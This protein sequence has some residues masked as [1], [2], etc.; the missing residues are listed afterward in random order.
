MENLFKRNNFSSNPRLPIDSEAVDMSVSDCIYDKYKNVSHAIVEQVLPDGSK[1]KRVVS[2]VE[3][4]SSSF[5]SVRAIVSE[6]YQRMLRLGLLSQ[7]HE[8]P[9][10]GRMSD[11]ELADSVIPAGLESDEV[12]DILNNVSVKDNSKLDSASEDADVSN[13]NSD[14][15][16]SSSE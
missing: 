2:D 14:G 5:P 15:N 10:V 1:V 9:R 16:S 4:S 8:Q 7:P 3:L 11:D 6:D 12:R 13:G